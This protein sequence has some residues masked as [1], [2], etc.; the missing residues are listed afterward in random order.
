M[1]SKSK[2]CATADLPLDERLSEINTLLL[3]PVILHTIRS[4][5]PRKAV[6]ADINCP[7]PIDSLVRRDGS[8]V[9]LRH[10]VDHNAKFRAELPS[11]I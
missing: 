3:H 8:A 6:V 9:R 4:R 5:A 1:K 10:T 2:V 7:P 11:D